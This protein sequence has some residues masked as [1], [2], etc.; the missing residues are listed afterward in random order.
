ME[1]GKFQDGVEISS[2]RELPS[3]LLVYNI[4][5]IYAGYCYPLHGL[6]TTEMS[7]QSGHTISPLLPLTVPSALVKVL[8]RMLRGTRMERKKRQSVR[9]LGLK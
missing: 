2:Y 7:V 8:E 5:T 1:T 9:V 6:E 3:Y 4:A